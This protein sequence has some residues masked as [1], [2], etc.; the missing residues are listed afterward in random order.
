MGLKNLTLKRIQKRHRENQEDKELHKVIEG[1]E[2]DRKLFGEL[3]KESTK[4]E[5]FDKKISVRKK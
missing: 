5:A 4:I 3:V 2:V 1:A